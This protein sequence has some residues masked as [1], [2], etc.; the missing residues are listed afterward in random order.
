MK[1]IILKTTILLV[2]ILLFACSSDDNNQS[3]EPTLPTNGLIGWWPFNG[4]ANDESGNGHN[5]TV[6]GANLTIDR[7]G[8]NSSAYDFTHSGLVWTS[9]LHQ[10]INVP[11]SSN[12]NSN[13]ISVSLWFNARSYFFSG[14][15][16]NDKNSRLISRFENGYS[17]PNGQT[18]TIDLIDG[19]VNAYILKS[20]TDNNQEFLDVSSNI[21]LNQWYHVV[22][23]FDN[24]SLKL[25]LNGTL[26]QETVKPANFSI[27]TIGTSGISIGSSNQA[28]G[29]WYE[30]DAKIDDVGF[31]N[32]ALTLKEIKDLYRLR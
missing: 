19:K 15:P 7:L 1:K 27:N 5:G 12:F 4:N 32:R 3:Q 6:S 2:S 26:V 20:A 21:S 16:G 23:T 9:A 18:W 17:N 30:S 14:I 29:F 22:M 13:N 25:Y 11:H 10:V 8:S 31:W 24:V 28:N